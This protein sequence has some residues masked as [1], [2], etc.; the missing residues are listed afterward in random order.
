[1][2]SL[3]D[4]LYTLAI[5]IKRYPLLYFITT[6]LILLFITIYYLSEQFRGERSI[7]K[8]K[9]SLY[10]YP[11]KALGIL[12]K[13]DL[14]VIEFFTKQ[15]NLDAKEYIIIKEF[16]SK[17]EQVKEIYG[18]ILSSQGKNRQ[19]GIKAGISILAQL[20]VP[21]AVDYLITFLYDEDREIIQMVLAAL[22]KMP[23][24]KVIYSL[25]DY[26][27]YAKDHEILNN[28]M[29]TLKGMGDLAVKK[30]IPLVYKAD[31][32]TKKCYIDI[33]GE[34]IEDEA[35]QVLVNLLDTDYP[36]VKI[37]LLKK[38]AN[39]DLDDE[40][41]DKVISFLEDKDW[42]VRS[43]AANL[44]GQKKIREAARPIANRLNDESGVVRATATK[45]LMDLGY[46][47]I[48]YIFELAKDPEAPKEV[49]EALQSQ[50]IAFIIK[51]MERVY[52]NN[53][54]GS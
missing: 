28:L 10:S 41:V 47:G 22:E 48:K 4:F 44:L 50:D 52:Q 21:Q 15:D 26:I 5:F 32:V 43:Q 53:N 9:A 13:S 40:V 51:A 6:G 16:L 38:L 42:G 19:Q 23:S 46:E 20:Q 17:P 25:L 2:Q 35:Y 33:I 54:N 8:I 34:Y 27:R 7:K 14:P 12:I 45:A 30:I 36:E 37:H 24:E 39:Y 18:K 29:K 1:M 3:N 49:K 31:P 11:E